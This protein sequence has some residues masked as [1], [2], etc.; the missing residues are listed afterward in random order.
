MHAGAEI[1]LKRMESNP[2][3]FMGGGGISK[4]AQIMNAIRNRVEHRVDIVDNPSG[5]NPLIPYPFLSDEE[6]RAL[7]DSYA[8]L[9]SEEFTKEVMRKLLVTSL[10]YTTNYITNFPGAILGHITTPLVQSG[11]PT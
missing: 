4:W 1:I 10:P 9:Q 8:L 3:E 2:E 7:Y 6:V 11:K 5:G